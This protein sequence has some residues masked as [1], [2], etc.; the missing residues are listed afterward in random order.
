[1]GDDLHV[2]SVAVIGAGVSGICAAAHLLRQGL[3]VKLFERSSIAGG[4][5]HF[6][7]NSAIDPQY[8]NLLPSLGDYARHRADEDQSAYQTPPRTPDPRLEADNE[9]DSRQNVKSKDFATRHAPPGPCYA[10]LTNNVALRAMKTTLGD[11]PEGLGDF[12]NQRYLEQYL[13]GIAQTS[14]VNDVAEY[15]TRVEEVV[16]DPVRSKW[17]VKTTTL[18]NGAT[19]ELLERDWHFDAVVVASGHYN[20]PRVPDIPGLKEWK[21]RYP[22]RVW[23]SKRRWRQQQRH[24]ERVRGIAEKV[25]QSS[26]GGDLDLPLSM[27]PPSATR[28]GGVRRFVLEGDEEHAFTPS[29]RINGYVELTNG[30]KLCDLDR[31]ILATGYLTSYPYLSQYHADDKQPE[32][33]SESDLVTGDGNMVHNLH[34]DIFFINDP[35][36]SFVGQPYH[37]STFSLFEFQAQ[38]VARVL[39]GAAK[40]PSERAMRQEYRERVAARGLGRDF[41]SLRGDGEELGYVRSLVEWMN[42]TPSS[43]I[44][45]MVG[46]TESFIQAHKDQRE[47]LAFIGR[48]RQKGSGVSFEHV[49]VSC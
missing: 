19:S 27:L 35:T 36:L 38:V 17:S 37:I 4:V 10:G 32:D 46:H 31:V 34:K 18:R 29:G 40:L 13:Q 7:E 48:S 14:G 12:V 2:H 6:D 24:I 23:H 20:M 22:D 5:W 11:W 26:R 41:H 42:A 30:S 9:T 3:E 47:R 16:K 39:S 45:P 49:A 28:I 33:A 8:P 25:F 44:L 1:M 21:A 43:G 15:N